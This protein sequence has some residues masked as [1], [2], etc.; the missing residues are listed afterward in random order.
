[1]AVD[2]RDLTMLFRVEGGTADDGRLDLHDASVALLGVARAVNITTHAF[3]NGNEVRVRA[4]SATGAKAFIHSS[5]KGCFEEQIDIVF[6]SKVVT[7]NGS[8]VLARNFWDYLDF[9]WCAAN[10]LPAQSSSSKLRKILEHDPHIK[11]VMADALEAAMLEMHRPIVK[12]SSMKIFVSRPRGPDAIMLNQST[13]RYVETREIPSKIETITGNVTK[14]NVLSD[15]GRIYSD[16]EQRTISFRL[17]SQI[18]R[19]S[20]QLLLD[21]MKAVVDDKSGRLVFRTR[22]VVNAQDETKRYI[23]QTVEKP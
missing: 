8:S 10:G 20:K 17:S 22:R 13:L 2:G 23:I 19:A 4:N 9:F 16:E 18:D 12:N 15:F 5:R 11:E 21:S 1:M 7:A 6:D 14:F 3:A